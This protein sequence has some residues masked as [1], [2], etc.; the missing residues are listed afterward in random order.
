MEI[1][2]AK[3]PVPEKNF[4]TE[5]RHVIH[6]ALVSVDDD[7][8]TQKFDQY[9]FVASAVFEASQLLL[10]IPGQFV[11]VFPGDHY[12]LLAALIKLQQPQLMLDIGTFTGLSACVMGTYSPSTAQVVTFDVVPYT[13]L[14][15]TVLDPYICTGLA[16][17]QYL[18]DLSDPEVFGAHKDLLREADF[19]MCDGPKD[20]QFEPKFMQLLA[21]LAMPIKKRWMLIDD[22]RFFE[23]IELWRAIQSPK[24]DL[25]SFGHFS[26]TGLVDISEGLILKI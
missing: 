15:E 9:A 14:E 26:G 3:A 13:D 2:H 18:K 11:N 7:P 12:R 4:V 19:I 21:G 25:T 8:A 24:I 22:I 5:P 10:D 16:I 23:M 6:S 1:I 20:G 17:D